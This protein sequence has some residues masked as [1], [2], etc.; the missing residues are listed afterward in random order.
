G[1]ARAVRVGLAVL[2]GRRDHRGDFSDAGGQCLVGAALVQ[3]QRHAV[4]PRERRNRMNDLA[5]ID[6]LREGLGRQE[7]ADLEMPHARGIFVPDPALLGRGRG[8]ALDE[9]QAVAQADLTQAHAA[10]GID[11]LDAGHARLPAVFAV[12]GT[13]CWSSSARIVAVSAPSGGTFKPSPRWVPFHSTG[14]AGTRNAAPSALMLL[15]RPPGRSTCGSLSRSSG[16]LIGEK[17]ILSVSSFAE[18]SATSQYLISSATRGRI[19]P[20]AMM[21]SVVVRR[22]GSSRSSRK[23]N[24][25]QK[26][27]QC[28]SVTTPMKM[29]FPPAVSKMS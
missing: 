18:S 4:S 9:L 29:R 11:V 1:F 3:H 17:Q 16:R 26:L 15:T 21:R 25:A 6:E 2:F 5:H 22:F 20:R 28:P 13:S 8:K 24:S 14:S 12:A 19:L 23:P 7:R 27:R 10:F